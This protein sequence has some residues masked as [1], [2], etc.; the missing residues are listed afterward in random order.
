MRC[1][2]PLSPS[3]FP[4]FLLHPYFLTSSYFLILYILSHPYTSLCSFIFLPYVEPK[5]RCFE[6]VALRYLCEHVGTPADTALHIVLAA[7]HLSN[8]GFSGWPFLGKLCENNLEMQRSIHISLC[9]IIVFCRAI[10][11]LT[12]P[13][14][15]LPAGR[16]TFGV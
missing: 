2:E 7:A 11:C 14:A 6:C 5:D 10:L 8:S 16:H 4:Y 3:Q 1:C 12:L 9:I 15:R 13:V